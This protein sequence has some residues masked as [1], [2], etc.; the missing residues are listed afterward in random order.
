[1]AAETRSLRTVIRC[2]VK[3]ERIAQMDVVADPIRLD[4][5]DLAVLDL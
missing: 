3:E 2:A 5:L 4:H 1:M